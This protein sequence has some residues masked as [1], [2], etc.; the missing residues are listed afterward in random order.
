MKRLHGALL[1]LLVITTI[2]C[3]SS[4]SYAAK[5]ND[6][7]TIISSDYNGNYDVVNDFGY[8]L[9]AFAV[10]PDVFIAFT[11]YSFTYKVNTYFCKDV[12]K[13]GI[14]ANCRSPGNRSNKN[15]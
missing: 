10:M 5:N 14:R 13:K 9:S 1:G 8:S 11:D 12:P 7:G 6:S 15:S 2:F 3:V 4:S